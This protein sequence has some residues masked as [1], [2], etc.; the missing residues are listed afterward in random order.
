MELN[1]PHTFRLEFPEDLIQG[2]YCKVLSET[3]QPESPK[4]SFCPGDIVPTLVTADLFK[5]LNWLQ[6]ESLQNSPDLEFPGIPL[7]LFSR[8]FSTGHLLFHYDGTSNS[9]ELIRNFISLFGNLVQN[10]KATI[11]SPSFIPKS[12]IREEQ[13]VIQLVAS[14]VAETS[15]IKFNFTRIGDFWSYG[16]K[17]GC[18]LLVTSRHY[19]EDLLRLLLQFFD[20]KAINHPL[21]FY[22][23]V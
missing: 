18:T 3:F 11:I 2:F 9:T 6:S 23:S 12:K 10:S 7:L 20:R 1:I 4:S 14:S 8:A 15:F 5:T 22:L 21:S 13:E 16:M 17:H 19:Q